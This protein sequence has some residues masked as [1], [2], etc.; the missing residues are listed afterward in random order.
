MSRAVRIAIVDSGIHEDH[1]HVG[2]VTGGIGITED[3]EVHDDYVMIAGDPQNPE[4][5]YRGTR[6]SRP[7][8]DYAEI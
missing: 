8:V 4:A 6:E 5:K 1:P 3:G 7:L 2:G